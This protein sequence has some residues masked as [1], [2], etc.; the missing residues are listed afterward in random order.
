MANSRSEGCGAAAPIG[1]RICFSKSPFPYK[2]Q[3]LCTFAIKY[4]EADILPP[5]FKISGSTIGPGV[6]NI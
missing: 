6:M 4:D 1:L 2:T 3:S 5:L